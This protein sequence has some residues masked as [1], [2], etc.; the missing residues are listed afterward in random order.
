[1]PTTD[2]N[3]T[4]SAGPPSALGGP[5]V[6]G[7]GWMLARTLAGRTTSFAAQVVLGWYCSHSDFGLYALA[8]SVAGLFGVFR[9]LGVQQVLIQK[10][11]QFQRLQGPAFWLSLTVNSAVA[12]VITVAATPVA[13]FYKNP[14]IAHLLWVIAASIPLAG[15]CV[16]LRARL[17]SSLR[18]RT[19]ARIGITSTMLR[20]GLSIVLAITGWGPMSF[21]VPLPIVAVY[22]LTAMHLATRESPWLQRPTRKSW[23]EL[24]SSGKWI[25]VVALGDLLLSHGDYFGLGFVASAA[26]VGVYFFA[27]QLSSQILGALVGN[28][29][30]VLFPALAQLSSDRLR[31]SAAYV[32]AMRTIMVLVAPVTLLLALGMPALEH[33]VWKGRWAAAV[34]VVQIVCVALPLRSVGIV[35]GSV[36]LGQG[37]F[38]GYAVLSVLDGLA[39]VAA[40]VIGATLG[41]LRTIALSMAI[42]IALGAVVHCGIAANRMGIRYRHV[43]QAVM[44]PWALSLLAAVPAVLALR[45]LPVTPILAAVLAGT[46][47]LAA[48][49]PVAWMLAGREIRVVLRKVTAGR[50]HRGA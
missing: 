11:T 3:G 27:F 19:V 26:V 42:Y 49:A 7:M 13:A 20:H 2:D 14:E 18:F 39:N 44:K 10:S 23:K 41:G 38:R 21:V 24:T 17:M 34:I 1:M 37:A 6:A 29:Q 35:N 32:R 28:L 4:G 25:V 15:A 48:Y 8:A 12:V 30:V 9:N 50:L 31:F 45:Y 46:V 16:T 36:F 33:L 43:A 22:E 47:L 5:V 40:A